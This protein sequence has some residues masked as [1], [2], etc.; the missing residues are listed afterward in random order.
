MNFDYYINYFAMLEKRLIDIKK[1][2]AFDDFSKVSKS[3][4]RKYDGKKEIIINKITWF[5]NLETYSTECASIIFDCCG[6]ISGF[7]F[8]FCNLSSKN[9][10]ITIKDIKECINN[11]FDKRQMVWCDKFLL[12]P[13]E[14]L[15]NIDDKSINNKNTPNPIWWNDY[16]MTKHR[17][18]SFFKKATLRNAMSCMAGMFS[19]LLMYDKKMFGLTMCNWRGIFSDGGNNNMHLSWHC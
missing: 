9:K 6:L 15:N 16:N 2:I 17:G 12:Q 8:D 3:K 4:T 11:N 10:R 14:C 19:L 5:S 18:Y 7:C 1:Y 13:W